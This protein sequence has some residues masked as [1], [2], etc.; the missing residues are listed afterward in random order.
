MGLFNRTFRHLAL[1]LLCASPYAL[2]GALFAGW[3]A[4]LIGLGIGVV[5]WA[6]LGFWLEWRVRFLL[7]GI[8]HAPA[9]IQRSFDR[10]I[11]LD[12]T[13]EGPLPALFVYEDPTPNG[14]A[15][16][17]WRGPGA[18][19]LSQGLLNQSSEEELRLLLL[20]LARRCRAPGLTLRSYGAAL[21]SFLLPAAPDSWSK[22]AWSSRTADR[23][24]RRTDRLTPASFVR[25]A[26]IFPWVL[27]VY[28][29]AGGRSVQDRDLAQLAERDFRLARALA[30][31]DSLLMRWDYRPNPALELLYLRGPVRLGSGILTFERGRSS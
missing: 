1:A 24:K 21:I 3:R 23:L 6:I 17:G 16:R 10:A 13:I 22:I 19:L 15:V 31:F 25:F 26:L 14:L 4:I 29:I 8:K 30:R 20:D 11:E 2:A 9:G 27:A 7:R 5:L 12:G 28:R 18:V